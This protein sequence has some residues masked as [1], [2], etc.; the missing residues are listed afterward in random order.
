MPENVARG[1]LDRARW[2]L[3][4]AVQCGVPDRQGFQN[5][6]EAAIVFARS[7][8]FHLQ[9]QYAA[10]PQF[11]TWYAQCR[12][13]LARDPLATFFLNQRNLVLKGGPVPIAKHVSAVM[14]SAVTVSGSVHVKV[15]RGKP[16]YRRSPRILIQDVIYP[17][18]ALV[19]GWRERRRQRRARTAMAAPPRSSVS[20]S[21]RFQ[22]A[23]W[24]KRPAVDLLRDYLDTLDAIVSDAESRF[25]PGDPEAV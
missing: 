11:D 18:R 15:I 24:D 23:P 25:G 5:L 4:R 8:T 3:S 17:I 21:L 10:T 19:N 16:W 6:F 2:F 22:T 20:E 12:Q 9:K 14:H 13:R 7:V 1:T